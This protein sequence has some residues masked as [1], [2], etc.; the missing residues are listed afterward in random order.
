MLGSS[1]FWGNMLLAVPLSWWTARYGPKILTTVT[2]SLGTGLIFFQS[3]A[4]SFVILLAGRMAF[5]ITIIA[6]QPAQA[7]LTQQWF[8]KREIVMVNSLSNALFGMVVGGGLASSPII[9]DSLGDDWRTTF[10]TF[11]ILFVVLTVLWAVLGR[12]RQTAN[13]PG[14]RPAL[15]LGALRQTLSYRD[16]WIVGFGFMGATGA[17][18]AFLAFYPTLMLDVHQMSLKMSGGALALAV[19]V[20]G[21]S[22]LGFG[23]AVMTWGR[24]GTYLQALGILMAGTYVGMTLTGSAPTVLGLNLLNGVA[25]GFWPVLYTVPFHL[26]GIQP[27]QVAVALAVMMALTSLGMLL[28]PLVAGFLQEA[29]DGLKWPLLVIGLAPLSLTIAGTVIRS[30]AWSRAA[31]ST[32]PS[33]EAPAPLSHTA[34]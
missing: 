12:E 2:M 4:P 13:Q 33:P 6:R 29:L 7:L 30:P 8:L 22:G 16:L 31:P 23:Y 27:Q 10:R 15:S 19:L 34:D 9:L 3:W 28:G 25:W 18:S 5:G 24:G 14:G 17:W 11:G 20:G 26:R 21:I 1:A 32:P